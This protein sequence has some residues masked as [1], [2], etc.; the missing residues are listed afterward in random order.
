M[1][2]LDEVES[3]GSTLHCP[4][5][6]ECWVKADYDINFILVC[7]VSHGPVTEIVKKLPTP[8]RAALSTTSLDFLTL[9]QH[10]RHSARD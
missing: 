9:A 1:G 5:L 10:A 3:S 2:R 7:S 4:W 8:F 6:H